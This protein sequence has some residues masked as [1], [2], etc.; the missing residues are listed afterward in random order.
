[1]MKRWDVQIM[2][3]TEKDV[4]KE[5]DLQRKRKDYVVYVESGEGLLEIMRRNAKENQEKL[6]MKI[7]ENVIEY[8]QSQM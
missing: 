6:R 5:R 1:M 4:E 7:V 2:K 3:N 8:F